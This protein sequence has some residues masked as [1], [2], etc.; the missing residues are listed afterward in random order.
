MRGKTAFYLL[1]GQHYKHTC[2]LPHHGDELEARLTPRERCEMSAK[3][4]KVMYIHVANL[5]TYTKVEISMSSRI[6][7][8]VKTNGI[9]L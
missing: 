3:L 2:L 9:V 5:H 7:R 4:H 1:V 6:I 8:I